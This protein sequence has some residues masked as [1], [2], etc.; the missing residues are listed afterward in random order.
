MVMKSQGTVNCKYKSSKRC[1]GIGLQK[2]LIKLCSSKRE[3][4]QFIFELR[5]GNIGNDMV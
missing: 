5:N 4:G 3:E 2:K 1:T